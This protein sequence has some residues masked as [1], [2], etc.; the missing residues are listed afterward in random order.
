MMK[1]R[2]V[3]VRAGLLQFREI[4]IVCCRLEYQHEEVTLAGVVGSL[5]EESSESPSLSEQPLVP[6]VGIFHWD[7][8]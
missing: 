6:V 2:R 1:R 7:L 3:G 5:V 8:R 4:N